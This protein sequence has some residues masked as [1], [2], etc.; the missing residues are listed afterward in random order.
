MTETIRPM[1]VFL[2]KRNGEPYRWI[3]RVTI[4]KERKYVGCFETK[5]E[6]ITALDAYIKRQK[7]AILKTGRNLQ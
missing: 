5:Q 7:H 4:N 2:L 6:A 3:V 1:F